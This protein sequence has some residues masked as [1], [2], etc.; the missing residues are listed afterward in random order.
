MSDND[1]KN[2]MVYKV[3]ACDNCSYCN[4]GDIS[5]YFTFKIKNNNTIVGSIKE[6]TTLEKEFL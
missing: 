3:C 4:I 2:I 1:F 6:N 5:N